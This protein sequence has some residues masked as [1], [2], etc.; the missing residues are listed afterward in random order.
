MQTH[1]SNPHYLRSKECELAD[2]L[3]LGKSRTAN[4]YVSCFSFY[5][6]PVPHTF[7]MQHTPY[8]IHHTSY[9]IYHTPYSI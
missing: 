3:V 7:P 8:T 2:L 4:I 1:L 5:M 6:C 9:P